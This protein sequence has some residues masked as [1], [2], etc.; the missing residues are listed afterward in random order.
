MNKDKGDAQS[1]CNPNL[2]R[3]RGIHF[4]P[5]SRRPLKM[6]VKLSPDAGSLFEVHN[7]KSEQA[8]R[9]ARG[10]TGDTARTEDTRNSSL[11]MKSRESK[12]LG[13]SGDS[14]HPVVSG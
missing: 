7:S 11:P 6:A 3:G 14:H 4:V 1:P 5:Y 2:H 9:R 8:M 13:L 10:L 12:T